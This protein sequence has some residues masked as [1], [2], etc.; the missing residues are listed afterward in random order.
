MKYQGIN[1]LEKLHDGEPYFFIRAQDIHS[2]TIVQSYASMLRSNGDHRGAN[3]VMEM[4]D[5]INQWQRDNPDKV[6]KP[7]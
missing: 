1:P 7:D 5:Q 2:A 3:N 6:K 4:V